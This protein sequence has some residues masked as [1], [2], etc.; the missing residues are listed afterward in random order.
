M[1][2]ILTTS[3]AWAM[4]QYSWKPSTDI[5]DLRLKNEIALT[6]TKSPPGWSGLLAARQAGVDGVDAG[7]HVGDGVHD[8]VG[9]ALAHP[10]VGGLAAGLALRL[11]QSLPL[12][13][14]ETHFVA[15]DG[16]AD[17]PHPGVEPLLDPGDRVVDLHAGFHRR[18]LEVDHVL[19]A[20]V[21]I[22][23]A[24][25]HVGGADRRVWLVAL[26]LRVPE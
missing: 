1:P 5:P 24:G 6:I 16:E 21:G 25:G 19:E 12:F 14:R 11:W 20:H 8:V 10:L 26:L 23:P 18:D 9:A 7:E 4:R 22:R 2:G 15:A 3:S 17:R 13:E